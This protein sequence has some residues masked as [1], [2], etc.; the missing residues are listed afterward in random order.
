M[1]NPSVDSPCARRAAFAS[2]MIAA[3]IGAD[4]DV[5]SAI[6]EA[7]VILS[8]KGQW[9]EETDLRVAVR[10]QNNKNARGTGSRS[11]TFSVP[12]TVTIRLWPTADTSG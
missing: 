8:R 3:H 1:T 12:L 7:E 10:I 2:P 11:Q 6:C 5:P 4:A 9:Q